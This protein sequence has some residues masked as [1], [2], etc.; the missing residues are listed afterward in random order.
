MAT[1][2][3]ILYHIVFRTK[4]SERTLSQENISH[5]YK[6]IWGIIS[7]KGCTLLRINGMEDHIHILSDLHPTVALSDYVKEIKTASSIWLKESGE[8]PH[9]KG[10]GTGYCALT[11]AFRD[12]DII[13]QYIKNQQ[14]HHQ[15]ETF[16]DELKRILVEERVEFDEHFLLRDD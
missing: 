16:Q 14:E 6:Y 3:Q 1:Y 5:L 8:F 7:N 4:N 13:T 15:R 9:F 11:Y 10:W 12:K 2:R